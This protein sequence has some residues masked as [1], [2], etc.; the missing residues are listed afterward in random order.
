MT[1]MQKET[2]SEVII[3]NQEFFSTAVKNIAEGGW[4]KLQV[5]ADFD[6]TLTRARVNG[7][8]GA[9]C[10]GIL[11]SLRCLSPEFKAETKALFEKYYPIEICHEKSM[12][13]KIPYMIKWYEGAHNAL[14]KETVREKDLEIAVRESNVTFRDGARGLIELLHR[15]GVPFLVFSAGI[16]DIIREVF[17][18]KLG[19]CL[20]E[21]SL[22]TTHVVSNWMEFKDEVNDQGK[23]RVLTG[24]KEPLIHM[25][26]K[27]E[28]H[29]KGHSYENLVRVLHRIRANHYYF[30]NN[31]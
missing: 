28:S 24:F 17:K 30:N 29:T 31:M 27:N 1:E 26:N 2:V 20:G 5:V 4:S 3:C 19:L 12:A 6:R 13:E 14:L 7:E 22:D 9:S 16:G 11:E 18:Q 23:E 15:N 25:F 10:H 8:S 21:S